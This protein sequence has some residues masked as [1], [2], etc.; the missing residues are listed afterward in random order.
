[1]K[2]LLILLIF[3]CV[4]SF[5]QTI[6]EKWNDLSRRYEY[7]NS[8]NQLV[9]YKTYNTLTRAW[10]YYDEK[11]QTYKTQSTVNVPLTQQV[12]LQKQAR[13]DYNKQ[14]IQNSISEMYRTL[15]EAGFDKDAIQRVKIIM[16]KNYIMKVNA[17]NIDLSIDANADYVINYLWVG[18]KNTVGLK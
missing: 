10:E 6:T 9:G 16:D 2:K 15:S 3:T 7:Y 12:M 1:M 14:R 5:A 8:N 11:P 18:L 17:M 4:S 13:Y